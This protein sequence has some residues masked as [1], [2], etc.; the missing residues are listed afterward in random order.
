LE[1]LATPT[2]NKAERDQLKES[3]YAKRVFVK[4]HFIQPLNYSSSPTSN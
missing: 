1:V 2:P 4:T 3:A